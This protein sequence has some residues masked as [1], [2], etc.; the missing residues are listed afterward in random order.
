M[1]K[2]KLFRQFFYSYIGCAL[3]SSLD[4][5]TPLDQNYT[6]SDIDSLTWMKLRIE[7][8]EFFNSVFDLISI[9]PDQAGHDFWLTRNGHGAGFWDG[10]WPEHGDR[11]TKECKQYAEI[12]LYIGD[13]NKI[14]SL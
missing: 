14:Y 4:D 3:W 8:R 10:D 9:N 11:L 6:S 7:A 5:E 1:N 13:D 2:N 12:N